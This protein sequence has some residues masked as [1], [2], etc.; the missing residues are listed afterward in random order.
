MKKRVPVTMAEMDRFEV[1]IIRPGDDGFDAAASGC[2]PPVMRRRN[3]PPRPS[4]F[5]GMRRGRG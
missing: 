5:E 1:K 2:L 4:W 3:D